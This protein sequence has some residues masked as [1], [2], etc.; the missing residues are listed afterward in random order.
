MR[1]T[2]SRK[3]GLHYLVLPAKGPGG[4]GA[5]G[6]ER[7]S[8]VRGGVAGP[9]GWDW[10]DCKM[11]KEKVGHTERNYCQQEVLFQAGPQIINSGGKL[12][13]PPKEHPTHIISKNGEQKS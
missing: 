9:G 13:R 11:R 7:G 2:T 3:E 1:A 12:P 4:L 6:W 5:E 10:Q 8:G